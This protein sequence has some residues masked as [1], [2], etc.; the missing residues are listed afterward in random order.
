MV[1]STTPF[2]ASAV[3][4]NM[5]ALPAPALCPPPWNQTITGWVALRSPAG[6]QMLR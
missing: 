4:S 5:R 1:T 2:R 6:A 3:P